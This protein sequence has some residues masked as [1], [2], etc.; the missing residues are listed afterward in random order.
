MIHLQLK[1]KL[2]INK[3]SSKAEQ[4]IDSNIQKITKSSDNFA[5]NRSLD[6]KIT[7]D[8]IFSAAADDDDDGDVQ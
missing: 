2:E 8:E 6:R 5:W 3:L 1:S 4:K 7:L